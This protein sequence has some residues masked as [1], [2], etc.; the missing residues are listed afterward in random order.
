MS[1]KTNS[2]NCLMPVV[3]KPDVQQSK[4]NRSGH[5]NGLKSWNGANGCFMPFSQPEW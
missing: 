2:K 1:K 4:R 5:V 3:E